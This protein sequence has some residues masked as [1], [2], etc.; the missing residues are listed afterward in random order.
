[1]ASSCDEG[2]VA[3]ID[4]CRYLLKILSPHD[5]ANVFISEMGIRMMIEKSNSCQLTTFLQKDLFSDYKFNQSGYSFRINL[6]TMTDFISIFGAELD[7][8][9]NPFGN[10]HSLNLSCPI[11]RFKYKGWHAS[12]SLLIIFFN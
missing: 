1:M 10:H 2:F 9:D 3:V 4:D 8:N 11:L 12:V 7:S 5:F 6:K